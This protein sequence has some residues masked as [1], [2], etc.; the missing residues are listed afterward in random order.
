MGMAFASPRP[1]L[2]SA[3]VLFGM[4]AFSSTPRSS[5]TAHWM[6]V[7]PAPPQPP[8]PLPPPP[9]P[10]SLPAP[11]RPPQPPP[12]PPGVLAMAQYYTLKGSWR[13]PEIMD[14]LSG[15]IIRVLPSD[16]R[17]SIVLCV[18]EP[19]RLYE[20]LLDLDAVRPAR[21]M[22]APKFGDSQ[23]PRALPSRIRVPGRQGGRRGGR[24]GGTRLVN[25]D[26]HDA[27]AP[28]RSRRF[29]RH[30]GHRADARARRWLMEDR[31]IR[32][33]QS[34]PR[35]CHATSYGVPVEGRRVRRGAPEGARSPRG[36]RA[37]SARPL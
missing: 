20:Y 28:D 31:H 26:A 2:L 32:G 30:G 18:N 9:S 16:S 24:R 17:I 34:R 7:P 36:L 21:A 3:G 23:C 12:H 33:V 13:L 14:D 10:P 6:L 11:L 22:I 27:S 4:V 25:A 15:A 37:V 1:H 8:S 35:N 29:R 19:T 5:G